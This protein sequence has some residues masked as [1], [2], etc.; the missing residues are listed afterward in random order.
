METNFAFIFARKGSKGLPHKNVKILA[1]KPLI[2]YSI[3]HALSS[4]KISNLFISTDCNEIRKIAQYHGI[5]T[6]VRPKHLATDS[7]PEW[8]SW[9]H[10]VDWVEKKFG[11]FDNFISL[12][13]TSPLRST[14]DIDN[15]IKQRIYQDAD[16]CIGIT[17][18]NHN[19]YFNMVEIGSDNLLKISKS[20]DNAIFRRQDV[21]K[22]YNITTSVYVAK[23][24][25]IR[26]KAGI[27]DGNVTS[28][29]IPKKRS[30]D[31]DDIYDFKYAEMILMND[32]GKTFD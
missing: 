19:P 15:A 4:K 23:P 16:I 17:E 20:T 32:V 12:P 2:Q 6:I 14:E 24:S 26:N 7:S 27:F 30:V 9:R 10:A 3:E 25:F 1:N 11:K 18:T 5:S 28:I 31:I 29:T 21:P 13:A 22:V 8:L